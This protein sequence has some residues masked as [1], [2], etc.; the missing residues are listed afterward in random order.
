MEINKKERPRIYKPASKYTANCGLLDIINQ[1]YA[2]KGEKIRLF[3]LSG[4][5]V[6]FIQTPTGRKV[7]KLY[8]PCYTDGAVQ[9]THI[10]PY[11]NDCGYP[12]VQIIPSVTGELFIY[13][14]RPEGRCVGILFEYAKGRF[15]ELWDGNFEEPPCFHPLTKQFSRQMGLLHRLMEDYEGPLFQKSGEH[16]F[17][18]MIYCL[19]RDNY[20]EAKTRDFEEY[21]NELRHMMEK[22]N[23][24][25]LHGDTHTG[26]IKYLGGKFIWMDFDNASLSYPVID[27]SWLINHSGFPVFDRSEF[28]VMRRLFDEIYAGYSVERMLTDH[29]IASV[30]HFVAVIFY[31]NGNDLMYE[32]KTVDNVFMDRHH[33]WLMRWREACCKLV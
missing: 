8:R 13:L 24:G 4:G 1:H 18:N 12:V 33:D 25:Y 23:A 11:L 2:V 30:F 7:F 27:L 16:F 21:G 17:N 15:M 28:D 6:F 29:E 14:N 22:C 19:R 32:N 3:R 31:G 20:D 26:N 10:L 9:T 5:Q